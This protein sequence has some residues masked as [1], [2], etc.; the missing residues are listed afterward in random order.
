MVIACVMK[1]GIL[2]KTVHCMVVD[3]IRHAVHA[4]PQKL[5]LIVCLM[6]MLI[7]KVDAI[8]RILGQ[9]PMTVVST[10]E[11]AQLSV[12]TLAQARINA[13]LVPKMRI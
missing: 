4:Q 7:L 3:V 9:R 5:V 12:Q 6:L 10:L 1:N 8:A 2:L 11:H 13:K